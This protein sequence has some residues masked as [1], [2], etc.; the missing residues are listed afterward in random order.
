MRAVGKGCVLDNLS[1]RIA[2]QSWALLRA[3]G[4]KRCVLLDSDNPSVA[5]QSWA[6]LRVCLITLQKRQFSVVASA[7]LVSCL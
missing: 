6:L 3:G 5:S 2:I 1:A 7:Q 4:L